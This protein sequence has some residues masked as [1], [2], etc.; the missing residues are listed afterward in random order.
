MSFT[1]NQSAYSLT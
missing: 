1:L